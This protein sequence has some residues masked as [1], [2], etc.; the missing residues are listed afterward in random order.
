M[1]KEATFTLRCRLSTLLFSCN[2]L[3]LVSVYTFTSILFWV[4]KVENFLHLVSCQLPE[5]PRVK[6]KKTSRFQSTLRACHKEPRPL[7]RRNNAQP[8][9]VMVNQNKIS[10]L[11]VKR[12]ELESSVTMEI[13]EDCNVFHPWVSLSYW[14]SLLARRSRS[15]H[16]HRTPAVTPV[17][18]E[19]ILVQLSSNYSRV[20]S[21]PS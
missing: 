9:V 11:L 18:Y 14:G 10:A 3:D 21:N 7:T 6:P 19:T 17:Y 13:L 4:L 12:D 16:Y 20:S 2:V 15:F 5:Y 8:T 1:S